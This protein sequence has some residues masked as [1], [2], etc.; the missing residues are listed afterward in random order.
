MTKS[1]SSARNAL[2]EQR[3]IEEQDWAHARWM[4]RYTY[5]QMRALGCL[6]VEQGGLGRDLSPV[7]YKNL[8]A[9]AREAA[10]DLTLSREDRL[11]RMNAE[12]DELARHLRQ[13]LV[14]SGRPDEYGKVRPDDDA[15]KLLL[16]VQKREAELNGVDAAKRI[17]VDLTTTTQLDAEIDAM[18]AR[19]GVEAP[20]E[21][22][23]R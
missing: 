16:S 6:P 11:E 8:V 10:G 19:M 3:I 7:A 15:I 1:T 18:L 2:I 12:N 14:N 22:R 4:E 23:A 9:S 5:R 17:D 20:E 13:R 21:E